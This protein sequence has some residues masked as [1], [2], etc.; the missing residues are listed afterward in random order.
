V[1]PLIYLLPLTPLGVNG[2]FWAEPVSNFFG[3][4]ACFITMYFTVYKKL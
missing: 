2:V 4:A 1:I 3:G